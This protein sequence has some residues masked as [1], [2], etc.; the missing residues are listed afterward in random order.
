MFIK[1]VI[2]YTYSLHLSDESLHTLV[3][4]RT[5][6][7]SCGMTITYIDFTQNHN[8]NNGNH[9]QSFPKKCFLQNKVTCLK[10]R[11]TRMSSG[12][13]LDPYPK[14]VRPGKAWEHKFRSTS[15][16]N[17][18]IPVTR[19]WIAFVSMTASNPSCLCVQTQL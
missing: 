16:S 2:A 15:G 13:I 19:V 5:C 10:I 14:L 7:I 17:W 1:P 18:Y 6:L 11:R 3:I 8:H 9:M 12:R 4:K